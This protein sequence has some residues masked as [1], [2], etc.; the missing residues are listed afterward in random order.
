MKR[1]VSRV[2]V[3]DVDS[4]AVI[5]FIVIEHGIR[6]LAHALAD[7]AHRADGG[8]CGQTDHRGGHADDGAS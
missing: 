4:T 5:F 8:I 2:A 3:A 7:D 1:R 6:R